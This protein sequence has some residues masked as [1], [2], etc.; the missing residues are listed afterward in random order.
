MDKN[1]LDEDKKKDDENDP[2][3]FFKFAGPEDKKDTVNKKGPQDKKE[4]DNKK[5][6]EDKKDLVQKN[7]LDNTKNISR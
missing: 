4:E 2:Y 6:P 3:K 5:G 7:E 1:Q